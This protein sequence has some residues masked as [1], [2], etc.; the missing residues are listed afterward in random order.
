MIKLQ[1]HRAYLRY[2]SHLQNQNSF[3][4]KHVV[5]AR[6]SIPNNFRIFIDSNGA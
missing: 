6:K 2:T 3:N 5:H 1:A 4:Q